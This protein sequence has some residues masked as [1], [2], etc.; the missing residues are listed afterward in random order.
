MKKTFTFLIILAFIQCAFSQM[1]ENWE[2][3][4]MTV[5]GL[6]SGDSMG[7]TLPH[8]HVL[9]VHKNNYLDLTDE[10]TA[11][12]ELGY[13][14]NAGGK[15]L[16]EAS[17]IGIGRN[18]EGLKRI[19]TAT[20]VNVIMSAG[21]YKDLW[22]P[23]SIKNKTVGQLTETIISDIMNGIGGIHAGFIKIAVSRPITQF[24]EKAIIAAAHAQKAT[25]AAID[26]HFDGDLATVEE[27]HHVLNVFEN[28]GVDL[29]RVYL[30]HAV[31]YVDLVDDFISL[32]Q[33]G[34]FLSFDML[35]LE[36]RVAFQH[37]Q[38]LAETLHALIDAGYLEQILISQDVCFSVCYVK[39]GGFGYAHILNNI[40]PQLK[41]SGIT[42]EQ[43][44]TLIV[45]NP[46]R[47]LPFKGYTVVDQCENETYT[48]A[49]GTITDNSGSS[50]YLNR[51][52]C[53]KLIQP[54]GTVNVTLAFSSFETESGYDFVKVYDG[55]NTSAPLLGQFSGFSLPA[56]VTS[57]GGSML[58]VFTTDNGVVAAG[59]S[60]TYTGNYP[61]LSV[62]PESRPVSAAKGTTAF[63]VASNIN[64]S[65]SEGSG[66]LTAT[67]TDDTTLTV[68]YD[69]NESVDSRSSEITV[70]GA[71][72]TSQNISV[73]QSGASPALSV[74]PP[75]IP[76]SAGSGTTTFI[77]ASN[78]YWSVSESSVWLTATKT[79]DTTLTVCYD[80]NA[81]TDSRSAEITVSG[82]GVTSHNISVFQ[83]G[84]SPALSVTPQSIPVSAATGTITFTVASNVNWSVSESSGWL[85]VT[86]TD[87]T[88]FSVSY[89]ENASTDSRLA[90]ITVSG[91]GVASQNIIVNQNGASPAL[92]VIP[93]SI[94]VSAASGTTTFTVA[95]NINWSAS[96]SSDWLTA[97]KTDD[98]TLTATYDENE[99]T[100]LRSAEITVSGAGVNSLPVSIKQEG[101]ILN[102]INHQSE[103]QQI[104]IFPNPFSNKIWLTYP[105][106][107]AECIEIYEPSGRLIMRLQGSDKNGKTEIDLSGLN[108]GLYI[109]RII[110]KESNIYNG[111]I[112]REY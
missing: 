63:T 29:H 6:I 57:T 53:S 73:I 90:E 100:D 92:M 69:E 27:K 102:I 25:G 76:V 64:W 106:G 105:E 85:T 24:E 33:R 72:V 101:A 112:V 43:I 45:E 68:A 46:K 32:A 75:S 49:S 107:A 59:W 89:G 52:T 93:L 58:I 37:E 39:N 12:T 21:Y 84:A 77:V 19:S 34:C 79:D 88:T 10:A 99:G 62:S 9:I 1:P 95:S 70:N 66:W 14:V 42:A 108:S 91:A 15:T 98:T 78:I 3:K 36:V 17:A 56:A 61:V 4:I 18:P 22:I 50:N 81:S 20:G 104:N 40:A 23:D 55:V 28:E 65:V 31:P 16:A 94:Q 54:S 2:G 83:S 80:E 47:I 96:E 82:S 13:Y 71:G 48:A 5:K 38:K 30:S 60:A 51:T 97:T 7:I 86:K 109:Y 41:A 103:I 111:K 67:K 35:G 26:V 11:I 44:H 74:T 8:E 110:D 87:D